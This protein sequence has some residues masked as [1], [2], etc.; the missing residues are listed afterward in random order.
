L[1]GQGND[2]TALDNLSRPG[3]AETAAALAQLRGVSVEPVD[4]RSA[5]DVAAVV[6]AARPDV[7]AHLAA[8]T[9]V[10]GS[11][12]DP[13][14]DFE[15]NA[16]GTLHLLEALRIFAGD[17]LVLYASTNKVYGDLNRVGARL[18]GA[19]YVMPDRPEGIDEAE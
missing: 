16:K 2:V 4:I 14:G 6:R 17:A 10:T 18:E 11:L 15:V 1:A 8:Q 7:V 12:A 3:A 13:A 19:R 5:D 9:S